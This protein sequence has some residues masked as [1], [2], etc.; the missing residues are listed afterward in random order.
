MWHGMHGARTLAPG[1]RSPLRLHRRA[2][3][4]LRQRRLRGHADQHPQNL[5]TAC[6]VK[7][8]VWMRVIHGSLAAACSCRV[9][10][11]APRRPFC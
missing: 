9:Q 11:T 3:S 1:R 10:R 5:H 2:R 4:P 7:R 8:L 6:A